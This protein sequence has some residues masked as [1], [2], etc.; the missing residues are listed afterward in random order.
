VG[1]VDMEIYSAAYSY[2]V[3]PAASDS[4]YGTAWILNQ[5]GYRRGN[6]FDVL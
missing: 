3:S 5:K 1:E 6:P 2:R 4:V